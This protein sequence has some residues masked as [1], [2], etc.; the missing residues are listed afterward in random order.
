MK[1]TEATT[2]VATTN[3]DL[4]RAHDARAIPELDPGADRMAVDP[5]LGGLDR[6]VPE[7][8]RLTGWNDPPVVQ[9]KEDPGISDLA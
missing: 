9:D 8:R 4:L 5:I 3:R 7:L 6:E 2:R 1:R